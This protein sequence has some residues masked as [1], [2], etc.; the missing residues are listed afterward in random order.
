MKNSKHPL[1]GRLGVE[2]R[3]AEISRLLAL[4][5]LPY[6]VAAELGVTFTTVSADF[7]VITRELRQ[8][9]NESL[10]SYIDQKLLEYSAIKKEAWAAWHRS[11]EDGE[12][13]TKEM[14]E[15][16][17]CPICVG[18]GS[19]ESR[20]E[21][22]PCRNCGGAGIKGGVVKLIMMRE[23]RCGDSSY[24]KTILDCIK[25]ER[26]LLGLDPEK[27]VKMTGTVAV[28]DWNELTN[29]AP[30]PAS[31]IEAEIVKPAP[32]ALDYNSNSVVN[33]EGNGE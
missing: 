1:K 22:R 10:Q 11:K 5:Y 16:H 27:K 29:G 21:A 12:R 17:N 15:E 7:A 3:R 32:P 8:S 30:D 13:E 28:I 9:R 31:V 26:E 18:T 4:G 24:L 33:S 6:Q 19:V 20:G 23:G 25:A 2:E 14:I